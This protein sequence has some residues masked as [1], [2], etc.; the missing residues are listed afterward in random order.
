MGLYKSIKWPDP[1]QPRPTEEKQ[2]HKTVYQR[3]VDGE[4]EVK[5][6]EGTKRLVRDE[7]TQLFHLLSMID[8]SQRIMDKIPGR[9]NSVPRGM[10]RMKTVKSLVSKLSFDILNTA[11]IEQRDHITNQTKG[12]ITVT[13]VKAQMP[14]DMASE[15]G[16]FLNFKQVEIVEKALREQCTLCTIEDPAEQ[17]KC[18]YGKLLNVLPVN[19]A[20]EKAKGCGWFH[21]WDM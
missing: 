20:D 14:R 9:L 16:V 13:G 19:K 1:A 17:A 15:Y 2:K 8:L 5:G 4:Y 3:V 11:P 12:L 7:Q 10:A 18:P 21:T 6:D